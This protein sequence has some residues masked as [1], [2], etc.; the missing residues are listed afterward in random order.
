[1]AQVLRST[2]SCAHAPPSP[3]TPRAMA[4]PRCRRALCALLALA[5]AGEAAARA[6]AETIDSDNNASATAPT[7]AAATPTT[8]TTKAPVE[9]RSQR[10]VFSVEPRTPYAWDERCN[11][12]ALDHLGCRADGEHQ[13]CRFC[14]LPPFAPCPACYDSPPATRVVWDNRCI[15]GKYT[16]GCFADGKNFECR[17]CGAEHLDACPTTTTTPETQP[18]TRRR[19]TTA[20]VVLK[21]LGVRAEVAPTEAMTSSSPPSIS[22][23]SSSDPAATTSA[24]GGSRPGRG[25]G[26]GAGSTSRGRHED[27]EV[28][29]LAQRGSQAALALLGLVVAAL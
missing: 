20:E 9:A 4:S 13:E 25:G 2:R 3:P 12:P 19:T 5:Q 18:W 15:P 1:L 16:K 10:C 11:D 21:D 22:A 27:L 28:T 23:T 29:S 7:T 26:Q 14:D 17:Y 6:L 8:T 24:G